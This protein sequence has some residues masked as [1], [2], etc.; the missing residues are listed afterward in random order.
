MRKI[1]ELR[2]EV[3]NVSTACDHVERNDF[4]DWVHICYG[5]AMKLLQSLVFFASINAS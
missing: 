4:L 5:L 1:K 2:V 3:V